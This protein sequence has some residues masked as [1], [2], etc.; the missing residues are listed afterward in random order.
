VGALVLGVIALSLLIAGSG[1]AW[2]IGMLAAALV[3]Y[4]ILSL[5]LRHPAL[6]ESSP[7]VRG[8]HPWT[9]N[10]E[11][12]RFVEIAVVSFIVIGLSFAPLR[13]LVVAVIF[14]ALIVVVAAVEL[15]VSGVV[16]PGRS[17]SSS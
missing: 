6:R 5:S 8:D 17:R 16:P 1:S 2:T 13:S 4:T 10:S 12:R 11:K 3:G 9:R 7:R 14:V 15:V